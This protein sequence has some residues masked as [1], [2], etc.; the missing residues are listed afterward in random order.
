MILAFMFSLYFLDICIN[1]VKHLQKVPL[2]I[3]I[4]WCYMHQ[5]AG[6]TNS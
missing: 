3:S 1:M 4:N 5:D 2:D 6:K